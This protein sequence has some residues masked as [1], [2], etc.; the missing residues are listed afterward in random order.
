MSLTNTGA[1]SS[2]GDVLKVIPDEI[3]LGSDFKKKLK[4]NKFKVSPGFEGS[5]RKKLTPLQKIYKNAACK[6]HV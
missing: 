1:L 3:D 4:I 5:E 2:T 6:I